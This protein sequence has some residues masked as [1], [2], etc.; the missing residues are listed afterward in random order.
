MS[1][2]LLSLLCLAATAAAQAANSTPLRIEQTVDPRF[3]AALAWSPISNGEARVLVN[4]DADGHLADLLVSSYTNPAFATE[5]VS[6]LKQWRYVPAVVDGEP[7]GTRLELRFYFSATGRV[8]SLSV[9]DS[10]DVLFRSVIP[11]KLVTRVCEPHELDRPVAV[12]QTVYPPHPGKA[13][14]ATQPTGRVLID[15]YV[16]DHGQPRMPVVV[17]MTN[18]TYAQAAVWALNQWRFAAP[19]R[20]GQPVAVRVRQ[21]FVFNGDS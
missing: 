17:Q 9:S 12:V 14:R 4:V 11:A 5:A 18:E 6:A 8:V 7:V 15:F 16:D 2:R 13:P 3:P 1:S 20:D 10:V 19:L 21:Q